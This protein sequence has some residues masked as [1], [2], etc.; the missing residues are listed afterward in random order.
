MHDSGY[1]LIPVPILITRKFKSL[2]PDFLVFLIPIPVSIPEK[3]WLI[4]ESESCITG[5]QGID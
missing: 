4:L 1:L 3:N 5:G 2:I